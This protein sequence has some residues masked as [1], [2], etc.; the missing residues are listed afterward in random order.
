MSEDSDDAPDAAEE[1]ARELLALVATREPATSER[2]ASAIVVRARHQA[3]V[4]RPLRV[5]GEVVA[6]VL[7]AARGL[8]G[9][10]PSAP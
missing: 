1:R 5:V 6:A 10:R 8:L 9:G 3:A 4:A 2:F 7:T